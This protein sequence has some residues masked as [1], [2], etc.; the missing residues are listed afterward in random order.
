MKGFQTEDKNFKEIAGE[1][2][3]ILKV[4]GTADTSETRQ[5]FERLDKISDQ[6][7]RQ[8]EKEA[9]FELIKAEGR[10]DHAIGNYDLLKGLQTDDKSMKKLTDEFNEILKKVGTSETSEARKM[11]KEIYS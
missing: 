3:E 1:F 5:F 4:A 10:T 11:F 8:E 9:I 2:N 7:E 6:K